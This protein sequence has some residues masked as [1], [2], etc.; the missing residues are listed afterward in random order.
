MRTPI[1]PM[2]EDDTRSCRVGTFQMRCGTH[3]RELIEVDSG[4]CSKEPGV[5]HTSSLA[6]F[7]LVRSEVHSEF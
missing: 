6:A 1:P 2:C 5:V 4:M 7:R 3:S